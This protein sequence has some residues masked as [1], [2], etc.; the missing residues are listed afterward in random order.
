MFFSPKSQ[1]YPFSCYVKKNKIR[2]QKIR[3]EPKTDRFA[4]TC[5]LFLKVLKYRDGLSAPCDAHK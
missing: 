5:N 1:E 3:L 4:Q 2:V